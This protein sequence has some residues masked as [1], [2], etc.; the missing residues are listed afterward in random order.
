MMF[1]KRGANLPRATRAYSLVTALGVTRV[2]PLGAKPHPPGPNAL[3]NILLYLISG[4]YTIPSG[5]TS[6][7]SGVIG[8]RSAS[9]ASGENASEESPWNDLAQST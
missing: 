2:S 5:L 6:I 7:S 4:R 1:G 8:A 3:F 9:L